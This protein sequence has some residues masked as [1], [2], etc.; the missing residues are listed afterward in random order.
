MNTHAIEMSPLYQPAINDRA[1]NHCIEV[2][3]LWNGTIQEVLEIEPDKTQRADFLL[4]EDPGCRFLVPTEHLEGQARFG[5]ASF[6]DGILSTDCLSGM[7][8]RIIGADSRVRETTAGDEQLAPN[9][10]AEITLDAWCFRIRLSR[11]LA[12]VT[13][14]LQFDKNTKYFFGFSGLIHAL[15]LLLVYM[16]PPGAMGLSL[17]PSE[18][19]SRFMKIMLTSPEI[20]QQ[21]VPKDVPTEKTTEEAGGKAHAGVSGKM[22]DRNAQKTGKR[23]AIKGPPDTR[24]PRMARDV[25]K[26]M[27]TSAGILSFL[28]APQMPTSP[29]GADMAKGIDPENALGDL[30]GKEIG[31]SFGYGGLGL[32]G[33][34]RGGGGDGLNTIGV[35]RLGTICLHEGCGRGSSSKARYAG[36]GK[37]NGRRTKGPVVRSTGTTVKGSISKEVIR[38]IVH[39]HI[40][41]VKFCYEKG[42]MKRP[43]LSGRIAIKFVIAESGAVKSAVVSSSTIHDF[44]V[45][46]CISHTVERMTFPMPKDSGIAIVTYPFSLSSSES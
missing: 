45:E 30:M 24:D 8:R 39:R 6:K 17:D 38:R 22:G 12:K 34:G 43:D 16:V 20:H 9:E 19:N 15:A 44:E 2:T 41:E 42:L 5:L 18:Q 31:M 27:A 46:S 40:N 4:G 21:V 13:A 25:V 26:D 7:S 10:V 36:V 28:S 37:L 33:T 29:F 3:V 35:G 1:E 14:P 23:S 32:N 11:K